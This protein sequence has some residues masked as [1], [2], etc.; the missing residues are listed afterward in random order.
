[1]LLF[2]GA[3]IWHMKVGMQSIIDDYIHGRHAKELGADRQP[4][5]R[6]RDRPA[7][8]YSLLKMSF[9]PV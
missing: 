6:R 3:S 8:I 9:A 4:L 2:V 7:C 5:L 1:M